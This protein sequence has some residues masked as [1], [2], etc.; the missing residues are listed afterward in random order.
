[1]DFNRFID[2]DGFRRVLVLLGL[3]FIVVSI[4]LL[5]GRLAG[6]LPSDFLNLFGQ[7]ELRSIAGLAVAGCLLAAIGYGQN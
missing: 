6:L 7:S 2:V 3:V 1:M 5:F 4:F